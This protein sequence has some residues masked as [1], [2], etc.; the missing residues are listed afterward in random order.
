M[1]GP[2]TRAVRAG[3]VRGSLVWLTLMC[4][5]THLKIHSVSSGDILHFNRVCLAGG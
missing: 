4:L 3:P 2:E 1:A 5:T